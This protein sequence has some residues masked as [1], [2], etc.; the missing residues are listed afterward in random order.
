MQDITA[1][2]NRPWEELIPDALT[3]IFKK[4]P[5]QEI[6]TVI[7]R[8]CKS[9]RK[10]AIQ[11]DCWQEI[12][13]EDWCRRCKPENTDRMV[14]MLVSRSRGSMRK[15][16]VSGLRNDTIFAFIARHAHSLQILRIPMSDVTDTVTIQVAPKLATITHLDISCCKKMTS[17]SLEALG[18]H[19]KALTHLSR[20]MHPQ[21][22]LG[23]SPTDDEAFAI[24]E[25][26]SH[27]KNLELAYGLLT[28]A[29]MEAILSMCKELEHL[30]IRGCWNVSMDDSL[31]LVKQ[32]RKLKTLK[33][34]VVNDYYDDGYNS[35]DDYYSDSSC[36]MLD[37]DYDNMWEFDDFDYDCVSDVGWDE[38][39]DGVQLRVYDG[40]N[41]DDSS[42]W[43]TDWPASP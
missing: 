3:L 33:G 2:G 31:V 20:N 4:I 32:C 22:T 5:F 16:E 41:T 39:L 29:G 42:D 23:Q 7:P 26:M 30:D 11:P 17:S 9:W 40:T 25:H 14:R 18:K 12:N 6:L 10:V 15:L 37:D 43:P 27:L 24:A 35:Y 21:G 1:G 34:P 19:C 36:N 13:I 28:N 38:D 8:V